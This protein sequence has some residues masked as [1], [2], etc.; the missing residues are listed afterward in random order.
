MKYKTFESFLEHEDVDPYGEEDWEDPVYDYIN[1]K[2]DV[3]EFLTQLNDIGLTGSILELMKDKNFMK[4]TT[5]EG[6]KKLICDLIWS[7][8]E[9]PYGFRQPIDEE[10]LKKI[11]KDLK[12]DKTFEGHENIDPYGEEDWEDVDMTPS[13]RI[14]KNYKQKY[15]YGQYGEDFGDFDEK[16]FE[17]YP[18]SQTLADSII[19]LYGEWWERTPDGRL[20]KDI[21]DEEIPKMIIDENNSSTIKQELLEIRILGYFDEHFGELISNMIWELLGTEWNNTS[22]YYNE[23]LL[24]IIFYPIEALGL[25]GGGEGLW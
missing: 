2:G 25:G 13:Q 1:F 22:E 14:A 9:N 15:R 6:R 16:F 3:Y 8:R 18:D 24:G 21:D 20:V 17:V 7:L 5:E 23:H 4:R 19:N 12:R 10:S 11:E